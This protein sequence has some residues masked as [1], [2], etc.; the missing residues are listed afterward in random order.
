MASEA[1]E[2]KPY[3]HDIEVAPQ[4]EKSAHRPDPI[5]DKGLLA[6]AFQGENQEHDMTLWQ[7]AKTYPWGCFWAFIMA[8]TIV[9]ESFDMFLNGEKGSF[10]DRLSN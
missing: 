4:D 5:S 9:M 8:F 2:G 6:D 1:I 3:A 10:T 7:A